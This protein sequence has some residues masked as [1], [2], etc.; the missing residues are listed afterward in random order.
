MPYYTYLCENCGEYDHYQSITS[1]ALQTCVKCSQPVKRLIS[2]TTFFLIGNN[3]PSKTSYFEKVS[4][5]ER[6][7]EK[8]EVDLKK[9]GHK[10]FPKGYSREGEPIL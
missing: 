7:L 6:G 5:I 1:D 2:K 8:E 3:W 4:E 10:F 9:Q